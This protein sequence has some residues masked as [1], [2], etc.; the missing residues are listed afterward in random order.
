MERS[1][2]IA[3]QRARDLSLEDK[4]LESSCLNFGTNLGFRV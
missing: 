2:N 3:R 4:K 1:E